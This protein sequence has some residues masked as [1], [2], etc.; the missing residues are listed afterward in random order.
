MSLL[1]G[2]VEILGQLE[3]GKYVTENEEALWIRKLKKV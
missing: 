1:T 2:G 3:V